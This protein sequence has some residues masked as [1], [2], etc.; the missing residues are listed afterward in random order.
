MSNESVFI[1]RLL[2]TALS[3]VLLYGQP[4]IAKSSEIK[5]NGTLVAEP[6]TITDSANIEVD[7]GTIPAK[8][9]YSIYS[10]RTW[11]EK[12]QITLE[13]CDLTLGREVK[14]TFIGA[15]DSEQP[16][17]LAI[18]GNGVKHIAVGLEYSNG[19]PLPLNQQSG[20]YSLKSGTT[21]LGFMAYIQAS[22][23][24]VRNKE[25]GFGTFNAVAT[26]ALEYP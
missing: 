25:V 22:D 2:L 1:N 10:S 11:S 17:L 5:F 3:A 8:N 23:S 6:C 20:A 19:T 24:G 14:I 4:A 13:E 18:N 16:G 15:E 21:E 12:F 7:F 26:F 9:F